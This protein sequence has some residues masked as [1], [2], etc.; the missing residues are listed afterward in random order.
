MKGPQTRRR[1]DFASHDIRNLAVALLD[2][3]SVNDCSVHQ[4]SHRTPTRWWP[5]GFRPHTL[6]GTSEQVP[7]ADHPDK[8]SGLVHNRH[9]AD[10][11]N[12]QNLCNLLH[13]LFRFCR[14]YFRGH[15]T[16]SVH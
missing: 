2:M 12:E 13:R 16:R 10:M 6:I 4:Y 5:P 7:F 3:L 11:I 1:N 14:N 8:L 15:D 9:S